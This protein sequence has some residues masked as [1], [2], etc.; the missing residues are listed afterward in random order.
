MKKLLA[1]IALLLVCVSAYSQDMNIFGAEI[2]M[3]KEEVE[4]YFDLGE[5]DGV[6]C[7]YIGLESYNDV[8]PNMEEFSYMMDSGIDDD[9]SSFVMDGLIDIFRDSVHYNFIFQEGKLGSICIFFPGHY[10]DSLLMY[11]VALGLLSS[12]YGV[13]DMSTIFTEDGSSIMYSSALFKQAGLD[14]RLV[15]GR[16]AVFSL[17][18]SGSPDK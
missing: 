1:V 7:K 5:M 3:A 14:L 4:K 9:A 11:I 16:I 13:P 6:S 15:S 2:G 18:I 12:E 8:V 17:T 10:E